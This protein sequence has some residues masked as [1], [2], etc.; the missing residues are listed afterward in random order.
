V[1]K[2]KTFEPRYE[3]ADPQ[4]AGKHVRL[5]PWLYKCL[6]WRHLSHSARC[7]LIEMMTIHN[8]TNNGWIVMGVR[9]ASDLMDIGKNKAERLLKELQDLGFIRHNHKGSF[10][11]G[12]RKATEWRL[13]L[14]GTRAVIRPTKEFMSWRP[15]ETPDAKKQSSVPR[16]GTDSPQNRDRDG[17]SAPSNGP[18]NRDT[19]ILPLPTSSCGTADS[20]FEGETP[21]G[22]TLPP[23]PSAEPVL[24]AFSLPNPIAFE[25]TALSLSDEGQ[26]CVSDG[27]GQLALDGPG[28]VAK[29]NGVSPVV[30]LRTDYSTWL[31]AAPRGTETKVGK[32][33]KLS[34]SHLNNFRSGIFNINSG[35]AHLLRLIITENPNGID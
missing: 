18:Q 13:T 2:K 14:F 26:S 15:D 24:A 30:I 4:E 22:E 27:D 11:V 19:Y 31:K 29:K 5:D 21:S 28:P 32:R 35:A 25:S 33:M 10:S 12:D 34:R 16:T 17:D 1:A 20:V 8:G 23:I 3:A 7:L 9:Q 6:A